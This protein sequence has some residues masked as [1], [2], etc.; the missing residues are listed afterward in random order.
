MSLRDITIAEHADL[1]SHVMKALKHAQIDIRACIQM[2]EAG[3]NADTC[4][5]LRQTLGL[6]E[7]AIRRPAHEAKP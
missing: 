3:G 6:L 7:A 1:P 4:D 5:G 2:F